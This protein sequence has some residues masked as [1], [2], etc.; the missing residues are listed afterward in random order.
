MAPSQGKNNVYV[1]NQNRA[2]ILRLICT[3]KCATRIELSR[4]TGLNKMTISKIITEFTLLDLIREG[5]TDNNCD[6]TGRKPIRLYLNKN[7]KFGLSV[8]INRDYLQ[9]A[10]LSLDCSVIKKFQ[11]KMMNGLTGPKMLQMIFASID[12]IMQSVSFSSIL[13]IGVTTLGPVD[14]EHGIILEP[15]DFFGMSNIPIKEK[16][17]NRYKLPVFV[18]NYDAAGALTEYIYG[19]KNDMQNFFYLGISH[20]VGAGMIING[21]L[22]TGVS[23]LGCEIGHTT[24]DYRGPL[25]TCGNRGCLEIYTSIPNILAKTE[26][27]AKKKKIRIPK[28]LHFSDVVNGALQADGVCNEVLDEVC[29]YLSIALTNVVNLVE[30]EAVIVGNQGA[31]AGNYLCKKIEKWINKHTLFRG[32]KFIPVRPSEFGEEV[33]ILGGATLVFNKLFIGEISLIKN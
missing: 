5:E 1:K 10:L 11:F 22:Y 9:I 12:E 32:S 20:G 19:N 16:L 17:K 33:G 8:H 3:R 18:E 31:A 28:P 26:E 14:T 30:P 24:I 13:G 4:Y 27:K 6:Q 15:P 7:S 23:G 29:G 25:C 21:K 2:L